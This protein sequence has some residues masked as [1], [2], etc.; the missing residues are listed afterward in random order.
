MGMLPGSDGDESERANLTA[1]T[2]TAA[3][4]YATLLEEHSNSWTADERSDRERNAASGPRDQ[5][6]NSSMWSATSS[7]VSPTGTP[8]SLSAEILLSAVPVPEP[9]TIAPA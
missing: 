5:A 6:R 9:E 3:G 1:A 4:G 8:A 2:E 7:G